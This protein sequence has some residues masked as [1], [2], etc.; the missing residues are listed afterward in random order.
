MIFISASESLL[1]FVVVV[2][3]FCRGLFVC[4]G[5]FWFDLPFSVIYVLF[6]GN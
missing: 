4:F 6:F 5:L 3:V 1:F 2:V